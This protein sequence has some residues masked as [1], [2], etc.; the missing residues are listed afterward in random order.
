MECMQLIRYFVE[1]SVIMIHEVEKK[2]LEECVDVIRKSFKT[3][4]DEFGFTQENAPRFT[5]FSTTLERLSWHY[6]Q[7]KR[8]MFV[9]RDDNRII[10][11]YSLLKQND[12]ECEL[13]NLCVLAEYRHKSVG[14]ELL[15]HAVSEAKKLG[16]S[17]MNVGIVE[18]NV[19]LREWYE[20]N[21]MEHIGTKKYDFFPFTCGYMQKKLL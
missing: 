20:A 15:E 21:G 11:Y 9:Y 2:D 19:K 4:A 7:E 6:E 18:E 5:A 17:I 8:P 1:G 13:N 12:K 3:V 10:G 14:K 16:C